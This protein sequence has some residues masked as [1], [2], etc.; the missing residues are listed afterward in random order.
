MLS[1]KPPE[2]GKGW[3][4]IKLEKSVYTVVVKQSDSTSFKVA[5][6]VVRVFPCLLK[7]LK[8]EFRHSQLGIPAFVTAIPMILGSLA[9]LFFGATDAAFKVIFS[10]IGIVSFATLVFGHA[11]TLKV[12]EKG[13]EWYFGFGFLR[14]RVG[15]DEIISVQKVQVVN[16]LSY[17]VNF[18]KR[19]MLYNVS[20]KD[21]IR[22][23]LK[24]PWS[25]GKIIE[26]GTD[27]ADEVLASIKSFM[28]E[29]E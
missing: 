14:K 5:Y 2:C 29:Q 1:D 24:T 26:V 7:S 12:D 20:G 8:K 18:T 10:I 15:F 6:I 13:V 27:R 4:T 16:S 23:H 22:L 28:D 11:L 19:G 25:K 17:G 21:A 3:R 9:A